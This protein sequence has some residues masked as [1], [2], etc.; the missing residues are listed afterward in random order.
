[1]RSPLLIFFFSNHY[2]YSSMWIEQ[3]L[4]DATNKRSQFRRKFCRSE[5]PIN[6]VTTVER[7]MSSSRIISVPASEYKVATFKMQFGEISKLCADH[8]DFLRFINY[9]LKSLFDF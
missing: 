4:R 6:K 8:F 1:M 3:T 5:G 2:L 9:F 7:R